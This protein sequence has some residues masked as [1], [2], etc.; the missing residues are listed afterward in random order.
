MA[1]LGGRRVHLSGS[2]FRLRTSPRPPWEVEAATPQGRRDDLAGSLVPPQRS[3]SPPP[4]SPVPPHRF[5][6]PPPRS[7]RPPRRFKS[8]LFTS[9]TPL[10]ADIRHPTHRFHSEIRTSAFPLS[11]FHP[12][13][14]RPWREHPHPP[15][16]LRLPP[17]PARNPLTRR[18]ARSLRRYSQDRGEPAS[19][20]VWLA[21]D[22]HGP[23]TFRITTER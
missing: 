1:D 6:R 21:A 9:K 5:N 2:Q 14:R 15:D 12:L 3:R 7:P 18:L 23:P 11:T 22:A 8:R 19:T 10:T 17:R 4:R 20:Q 16:A 13:R